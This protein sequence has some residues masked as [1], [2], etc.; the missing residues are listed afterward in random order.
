MLVCS[1]QIISSVVYSIFQLPCW[2]TMGIHQH[3]ILSLFKAFSWGAVRKTVGK[4]IKKCLVRGSERPPAGKLNKKI[5]ECTRS[6]YLFDTIWLVN[7][8]RFCQH[9]SKPDCLLY[10]SPITSQILDFIHRVAFNLFF[11]AWQCKLRIET[12]ASIWHKNNLGICLQI[13]SLLRS[14]QFS[15]N[16]TLGKQQP[17]RNR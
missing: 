5:V 10:Q 4:K 14:E 7:F 3:P 6:W 13:L 15:N 2:C 11:I 1:V 8:N 9:S 16:A 12:I 17:L